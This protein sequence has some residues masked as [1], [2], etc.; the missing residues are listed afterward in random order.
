MGVSVPLYSSPK[1]G[2]SLFISFIFEIPSAYLI[3]SGTCFFKDPRF[4]FDFTERDK[5][6]FFAFLH[7]D[8]NQQNIPPLSRDV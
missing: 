5:I 1:I 8:E 3:N 4:F 2:V 6:K 7:S